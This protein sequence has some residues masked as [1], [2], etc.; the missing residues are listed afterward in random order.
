MDESNPLN[1]LPGRLIGGV[2]AGSV[3]GAAVQLIFFWDGPPPEGVKLPGKARLLLREQRQLHYSLGHANCRCGSASRPSV[4][5]L[6]LQLGFYWVHSFF[7]HYYHIHLGLHTVFSRESSWSGTRTWTMAALT[8]VVVACRLRYCKVLASPNRSRRA[9]LR[10]CDV[11]C[12]SAAAAQ[13]TSLEGS[14]RLKSI[15]GLD[16]GRKTGIGDTAG[17][18]EKDEKTLPVHTFYGIGCQ[19]QSTSC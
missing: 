19:W 2:F 14:H 1:A 15:A 3:F 7:A 11:A 17:F 8:A 13:G 16:Y 10:R 9:R 18:G 5:W 4:F 12:W 6:V